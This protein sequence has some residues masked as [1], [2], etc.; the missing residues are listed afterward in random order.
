M[1]YSFPALFK[2]RRIAWTATSIFVGTMLVGSL[3]VAENSR[4][5]LDTRLASALQAP[6][7]GGSTIFGRLPL[8]TIVN[9]SYSPF[10]SY[11]NQDVT[12]VN[13]VPHQLPNGLKTLPS[14]VENICYSKQFNQSFYAQ[15]KGETISSL[16]TSV[17]PTRPTLVPTISHLRLLAPPFKHCRYGLPIAIPFEWVVRF[18][19]TRPGTYLVKGQDATY[20]ANG[21]TYHEWLPW[22]YYKVTFYAGARKKVP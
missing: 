10:I 13:L 9:V 15:Y 16:F 19:A 12:L 6:N 21:S 2:R 8:G 11:A 22:V 3:I 17:L 1:N 5:Q 20:V 7:A 18:T 14:F 4:S